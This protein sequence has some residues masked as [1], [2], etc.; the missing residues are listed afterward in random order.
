MT[1]PLDLA[2]KLG[3]A[4]LASD[5]YKAYDSAQEK[6]NNDEEAT[7]LVD[8]FQEMQQSL[9]D[10]Q[11]MGRKIT[12]EQI[13]ELRKHQTQM[14]QNTYIQTYL[15]S[16][17]ELDSLMSSVNDTIGRVVGLTPAGG[18]G[19]GGCGGGCC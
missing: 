16:K 17:R 10:A 5:E 3:E 4:I 11:M 8:Q 2:E 15:E 18:G 9:R 1:T 6:M 12:Q 14:I 19:G 7:N 13:S